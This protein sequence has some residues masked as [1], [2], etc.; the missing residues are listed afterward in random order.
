M[1]R[2][3][4]RKVQKHKNSFEVVLPPAVVRKLSIGSGDY[5]RFSISDK[6]PFV[7]LSEV[8]FGDNEHGGDS[9]NSDRKD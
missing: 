7:A 5:L 4:I 2:V 6:W 8:R 9:R 3:H 1:N